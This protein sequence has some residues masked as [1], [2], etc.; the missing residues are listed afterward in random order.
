[1]LSYVEV[2]LGNHKDKL[3]KGTATTNFLLSS[4]DF[5]THTKNVHTTP[6]FDKFLNSSSFHVWRSIEDI[7]ESTE[8]PVELMSGSDFLVSPQ[9]PTTVVF[10]YHCKKTFS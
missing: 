6:L 5:K 8:K 2:F 7:C 3:Q 4:H 9:V 1:M 10:D